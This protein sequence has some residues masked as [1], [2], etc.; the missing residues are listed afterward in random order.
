M[1]RTLTRSVEM[2]VLR[3]KDLEDL[4]KRHASG[5][6]KNECKFALRIFLSSSGIHGKAW[7][8]DVVGSTEHGNQGIHFR[9]LHG[10]G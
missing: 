8:R 7:Q 1:N 6:S 4:F 9:L 5:R 10:P 2:C 3:V